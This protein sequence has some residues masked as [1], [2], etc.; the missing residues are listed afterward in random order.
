MHAHCITVSDEL[1]YLRV[2]LHTV[3]KLTPVAY[4][5][6]SEQIK[7]NIEAVDTH[8]PRPPVCLVVLCLVSDE[9]P[10][11]RVPL[12]T[13]FKLTPVAYGCRSEQIKF[14]IAA[15]D[16]YRPRPPVCLVVC[17]IFCFHFQYWRVVWKN[18]QLATVESNNWHSVLLPLTS[19]NADQ[20]HHETR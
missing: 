14:D 7:F 11:L 4:G 6:R 17:Y 15:A 1:P 10:Y 8:R 16:T 12:H 18:W 20:F 5:C 13:V 9:L 19:S 2:P 3:I